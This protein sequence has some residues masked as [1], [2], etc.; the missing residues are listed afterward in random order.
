MVEM[1]D[2]FTMKNTFRVLLLVILFGYC[3]FALFLML[4]VRILSE[5]LKTEK[6]VFVNFLARLHVFM[7]IGGS[8][9]VSILILL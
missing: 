1:L 8:I 4:R 2:F 9:L 5:T 6:S 7:V 3:A